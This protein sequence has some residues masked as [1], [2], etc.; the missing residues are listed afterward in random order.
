MPVQ[1]VRDVDPGLDCDHLQA[2][3]D[4]NMHR[5]VEL[6]GESADKVGNNIGLLLVS[7]LFLDL[8]DTQKIEVKAL[9]DRNER[10][11][12]L[13]AARNCPALTSSVP[14]APAK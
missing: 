5:R 3:Y 14:S 13:A 2:E 11:K 12:N 7:P 9:L 10:L 4:N 6:T 8:S 1:L